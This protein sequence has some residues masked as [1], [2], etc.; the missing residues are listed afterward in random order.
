MT[1]ERPYGA[2]RWQRYNDWDERPL[3]LDQFAVEDPENGFSAFAGAK[4]PAPSL[5][6]V[7]GVVTELDG[8]AARDFDMIDAFIARHHLD[9]TVAEEDPC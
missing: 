8:V 6:L 5:S 1:D 4:D 2:N 3:R 9:P 7:D